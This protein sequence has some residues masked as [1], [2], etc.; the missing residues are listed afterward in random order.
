MA[1]E[2]LMAKLLFIAFM[3]LMDVSF[4]GLDG[5]NRFNLCNCLMAEINRISDIV[6]VA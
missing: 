6:E 2:A 3:D 1:F 4:N 5:Y